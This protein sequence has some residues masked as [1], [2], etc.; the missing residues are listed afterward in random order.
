M[1][2]TGVATSYDRLDDILAEMRAPTL[3][4]STVVRQFLSRPPPSFVVASGA[5]CIN[6]AS[7]NYR[8]SRIAYLSYLLSRLQRL[9]WCLIKHRNAAD[10]IEPRFFLYEQRIFLYLSPAKSTIPPISYLPTI[11]NSNHRCLCLAA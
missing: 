3:E 4:S 9:H 11:P 7:T 6:F 1:E 10:F 2:D 5:S 8:A